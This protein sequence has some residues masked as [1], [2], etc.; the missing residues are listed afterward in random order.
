[1][2][3]AFLVIYEG[4]PEDPEAFL[5]YYVEKH[6]PLVWK[7][8]KI[9]RIEIERG[10]DGGDFFMITRLTFDAIEDL[11]VA[12]HSKERERARADMKNFPPFNG[13]VRRQ[14]VEIMD[15]PRQ[16]S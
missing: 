11:H 3:V 1:M 10:V 4:Q 7:F 14:A 6:V 5:H 16:A 9:R 2:S 13:R 15:M 12:I 8:P